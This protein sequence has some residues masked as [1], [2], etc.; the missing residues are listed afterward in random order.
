MKYKMSK[1]F[2]DLFS[3]TG[4]FSF[5]LESNEF[6][7]VFA[8]DMMDSSKE[9]YELNNKTGIFRLQDLHEI[10]PSEIPKHNIL[11]GGFPCF[12]AGT[13]VLTSSGYKRIEN[14][15][16]EKLLTHT[17]EFRDI[18]NLQRK[19]YSGY[20]YHLKLQYR[21]IV[22]TSEHPFYVR[23]QKKIWNNSNRNY[24]TIYSKPEWKPISKITD[25][26]YYGM[27]INKKEII[28]S[29]TFTKNII[30]L[31]NP[32]MWFIMGYFVGDGWIEETKIRFTDEQFIVDK[33]RRISDC[34]NF[35]WCNILKMFGHHE[36][37]IPEW[38][39]DAPKELVQS[40]I[41]GYQS[42]RNKNS[43]S[44]DLVLSL[45][46]LYLKLGLIASV[47]KDKRL[48]TTIIEGTQCG[49][50]EG[51]YVWFPAQSM[52]SEVV[53]NTP[54]YNFEVHTDNSYI[55]ENTIVHNCQ[56]FSLAGKK[57]GFNDP[58]SN[59]FWKII[60]II[61]H[62]KPS[63]I[64]LENVKNLTSH[65]KG[66]T[67]K[68]IIENLELQ[69]YKI[70]SKVLDTCKLTKI[71]QHRERIYIMGFLDEKTFESFDFDFP[72]IENLEIVDFLEKDVANKYYYTEKLKVYE[73]VKTEVTKHINTNTL[74]Q[75]R[76]FYVREN[77]SNCCPTLTANMGE[78][79]HNIPLLKDDRGIR[80][81]TP[82]ECFNLQ[83]FSENYALPN[84]SDS[85]L[86]KLA[87]NAVSIPIIE[88]IVKKLISIVE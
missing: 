81:L 25:K 70:K 77:K 52:Y 67:F 58:R 35:M 24:D 20:L 87:G 12:V 4:A 80:K 47:K 33:I 88:L 28:P 54:V 18:L 6:E 30:T 26:Y 13:K 42:C 83:G 7:C 16:N 49:F 71:P 36:K 38:V 78:G 27:V 32:D 48:P 40:F 59:V 85:K 68:I 34:A 79:G 55:V 62:H 1:R 21:E 5:V 17:G 84:I 11:C 61:K 73:T 19:L 44:I 56:P 76:R 51:S 60:E 69:G 22:C 50:I 3:G 31:D 45:Q 75:Y 66:Q 43:V 72:T 10:D 57:E 14:V 9:I 37:I 46:R 23:E 82:R 63:V 65:D 29:F 86:Y 39:H 53:Q 8:N 2:I 15:S 74:Y 41:D 64:I